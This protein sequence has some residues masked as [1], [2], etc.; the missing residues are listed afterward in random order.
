LTIQA[1]RNP[2]N[3][4]VSPAAGWHR[5]VLG[6]FV[7]V[8]PEND[9]ANFDRLVRRRE[10]RRLVRRRV[11]Y[12]V[13][14]DDYVRHIGTP[15]YRS[16]RNTSDKTAYLTRQIRAATNV[17][18]FYRSASGIRGYRRKPALHRRRR[19]VN[20]EPSALELEL[21]ESG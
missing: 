17:G 4:I 9:V 19:L 14:F 6:S 18:H 11:S 7:V 1:S 16:I 8:A 20:S 12:R 5:L 13:Y 3:P 10:L 15:F 2:V 21:T